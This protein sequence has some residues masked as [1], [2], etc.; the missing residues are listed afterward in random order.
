MRPEL[1]CTQCRELI[2]RYGLLPDEQQDAVTRHVAGCEAC[3]RE[4]AFWSAVGEALA[5]SDAAQPLPVN[6]ARAWQGVRAALAREQDEQAYQQHERG[7]RMRTRTDAPPTASRAGIPPSPPRRRPIAAALA[8]ALIVV[9]SVALFG[10]VAPRLRHS[11]QTSRGPQPTAT[12]AACAPSQLRQSLPANASLSGISM[13]SARD[14]WAVGMIYDQ[15]HSAIAP[16]TLMLHLVGCHWQPAG[17]N[18]GKAGMTAVMMISASDGWA[19]GTNFIQEG[20][21][22]SA[23]LVSW[24]PNKPFALHY[25]GG[26]WVTTNDPI[27]VGAAFDP[28]FAALDKGWVLMDKGKSHPTPYT[29]AFSYALMHEVNGV[30]QQVAMPFARPTMSFA[31]LAVAGPNDVWIAGND[32]AAMDSTGMPESIVAH[33]AGGHWSTWSGTLDG[34]TVGQ[35]NTLAVVSPSNVWVFGSQPYRDAQ[36]QGNSLAAF[37]YD[38]SAWIPIPTRN[39]GLAGIGYSATALPDGEVYIFGTSGLP[40]SAAVERCDLGG[41]EVLPPVAPGVVDIQQLSLFSPTQG[42]A[43]GDLLVSGDPNLGSAFLYFDNGQWSVIPA[44]G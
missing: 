16:R 4:L 35:I 23:P 34:K 14:G 41:C 21:I 30:W 27:A 2:P 7:S 10:V 37:H 31:G 1:T 11:A 44:A 33:Y 9:L 17:P 22:P 38:G 32:E 20:G 12:P 3:R 15:W 39:P 36:S 40:I 28:A 8:F 19:F 6:Q 13:V 43:V 24:A 26:Q 5:A 42:F 25:T 18:I 29:V